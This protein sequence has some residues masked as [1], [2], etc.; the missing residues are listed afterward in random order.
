MKNI[1]KK[2]AASITAITIC[3]SSAISS[4]AAS[5]ISFFSDEADNIY[6]NSNICYDG[7]D[8]DLVS[9]YDA[10][11][12]LLYRANGST[13]MY[14]MGISPTSDENAAKI[15]GVLYQLFHDYDDLK[16]RQ[17]YKA[18]KIYF[19]N[20]INMVSM[21]NPDASI[22]RFYFQW[23]T[24]EDHTATIEKIKQ[25]FEEAKRI[26][27]T[28]PDGT[29]DEKLLYIYN[30]MRGLNDAED[31]ESSSLYDQL[32]LNK[33]CCRGDASA[34][35]IISALCGL[36]V[37]CMYYRVSDGGYHIC[38]YSYYDDGTIKYTDAAA[39]RRVLAD[40]YWR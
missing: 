28:V 17:C 25:S 33:G 29:N 38:N 40:D 9:N 2:I 6:R 4:F 31:Y 21:I 32:I 14:D 22:M 27:Q 26:A 3:M 12:E 36:P 13:A 18:D 10:L 8:Y 30:Y 20:A 39:G 34:I 15:G 35:Y 16:I 11:I 1:I 7:R 37:G 24:A 5:G 23:R 19:D